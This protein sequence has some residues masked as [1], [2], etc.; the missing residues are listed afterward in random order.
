MITDAAYVNVQGV[1]SR[2]CEDRFRLLDAR[3]PIV[4]SAERGFLYAVMDGVGS[5]PK[6]LRAAQHVA[7]RL[8]DFFRV[9]YIPATVR[10]IYE[11]L[12]D[13]N[14]DIRSWGLM[15]GTDRS[16]GAAAATVAWLSPQGKAILFHG[17]DTVASRFDGELRRVT[18]EHTDGRAITNYLAMGEQCRIDV[19]TAALE[20]VDLLCLMTDG[21][22]KTMADDQIEAVLRE[23]REPGRTARELAS[24]ARARGS[25]DD[26]TAVIVEIEEW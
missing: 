7:D 1:K 20:E 4:R 5:A 22:T 19:E 16:L 6:A 10:G 8:I 24:R 9:E 3:V 25:R 12:F 23:T 26:I 14:N 11:L 21:I 17:G 2:P 15:E 13:V 18:R